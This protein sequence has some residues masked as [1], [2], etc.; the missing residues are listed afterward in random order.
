MTHQPFSFISVPA[1]RVTHHHKS[2]SGVA[3]WVHLATPRG[4]LA[5]WLAIGEGM[6]GDDLGERGTGGRGAKGGEKVRKGLGKR[7]IDR[8]R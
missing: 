7:E 8:D 3:F 2:Q 5:Y 4:Y 1:S 6:A